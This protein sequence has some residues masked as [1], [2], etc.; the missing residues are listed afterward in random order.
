MNVGLVQQEDYPYRS[1]N[2]HSFPCRKE[3]IDDIKIPKF[4]ISG[5]RTLAKENC[6][7]I[8]LELSKGN[9]VASMISH[10]ELGSYS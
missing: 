8:Q 1:K 10:G 7:A 6:Q 5:F 4:K 2:G 9:A 3:I